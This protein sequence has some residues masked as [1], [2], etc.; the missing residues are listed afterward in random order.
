MSTG[1]EA[2]AVS[3]RA[4]RR[5]LR[6]L[7]A[8]EYGPMTGTL[9]MAAGKRARSAVRA[10]RA[11]QEGR[12]LRTQRQRPPPRSHRYSSSCCSVIASM[13]SLSRHSD[14]PPSAIDA[15]APKSDCTSDNFSGA[16]P[17]AASS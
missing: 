9:P 7:S 15:Q 5:P 1:A 4:L 13:A 3:A 14:S 8:S 6:V 17:L 11:L 10:V 16:R 12:S 2:G